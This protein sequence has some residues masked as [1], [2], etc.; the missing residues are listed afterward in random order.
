MPEPRGRGVVA[1]PGG[2]PS[3]RH[4]RE[5]IAAATAS[6]FRSSRRPTGRGMEPLSK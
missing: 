5:A 4:D 3:N 2:G 1:T 6:Y